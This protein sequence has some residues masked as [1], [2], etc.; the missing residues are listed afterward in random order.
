[1]AKKVLV[2]MSGG[3]DSAAAALLLQRAGYEVSGVTMRLHERCTITG[4][5]DIADAR[6]VAAH[7]GIEHFVLDFDEIFRREVME[8]F[9]AESAVGKGASFTVSLPNELS[10]DIV[11]RQPRFE[12]AGGFNRVLVELS[13]A[14]SSES[15]LQKYLD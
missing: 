6:A 3:V 4:E 14:L 15:F 10:S 2:G 9:V 1:M 11:F 7:M 12:Y 13:D 8:R 5:Q